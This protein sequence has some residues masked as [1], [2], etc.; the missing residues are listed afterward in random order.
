[1]IETHTPVRILRLFIKNSTLPPRSGTCSLHVPPHC[2]M[3]ECL[4]TSVLYHGPRSIFEV[5][6]FRVMFYSYFVHLARLRFVAFLED[7]SAWFSF[8][9][10]F[11]L[12]A[13][14]VRHWCKDL[15][16]LRSYAWEL[17]KKKTRSHTWSVH[18]I[19]DIRVSW[20]TAKD[21]CTV[22]TFEKF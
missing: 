4:L 11:S 2:Y 5:C 9:R 18:V 13:S 1:M 15:D 3:S 8:S 14:W 20:E 6:F 12:L 10:C 7:F 19:K 22:L 21:R 16:Q 17:T